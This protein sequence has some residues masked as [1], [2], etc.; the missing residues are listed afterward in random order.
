MFFHGHHPDSPL[1]EG[2]A[3]AKGLKYVLRSDVMY[4][5]DYFKQRKPKK[6]E[7]KPTISN[8]NGEEDEY[9]QAKEDLLESLK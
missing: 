7:P 8:N 4:I 3:C 9:E 2:S 5:D 6:E 1:H